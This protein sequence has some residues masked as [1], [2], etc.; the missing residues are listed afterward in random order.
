MSLFAL[1][2]YSKL[3]K[4]VTRSMIETLI[5]SKT[6]IK[7]LLKFFLNS[8]TT[9]YLRSLESEF[10]ES[11]NGIRLELN[12]LEDAGMLSSTVK[13]NKKLFQ[14]N[15]KHPLFGEIHNIMMK[16]VGLDKIVENVVERLGQVD[17]VYLAG[18]FAQGI[19]SP[20]IDLIFIGN[21]DINYLVHLIDKV[22]NMI[23]RKV[24]YLIYAPEKAAHID[25]SHFGQEP[26][27]LWHET[28]NT[29]T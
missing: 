2:F 26:L 23:H 24:R 20:V 22:E 10:G 12:R 21:I 16:H 9:G 5:S 7:L 8:K 27:L 18:S 11:T 25:W 15:T 17:K 3:S 4:F 14:A 13:G 19:D 28:D 29:D 6:R 1:D